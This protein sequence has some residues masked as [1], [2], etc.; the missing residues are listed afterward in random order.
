MN[1]HP[2]RIAALGAVATLLLAGCSSEPGTDTSPSP[3]ATA[4]DTASI[5]GELEIQYFIGGYGEEWWDQVFADF[6][7]AYPDVTI[8]RHG[9]S[10]IHEEMRSRWIAND[11]PDV[12]EIEGAGI[13]ES[14]MVADG[15]LM[16]LTDWIPTI[17]LDDGTML[18]DRFIAPPND[19]DGVLY[20]LPLIYDNRGTWFDETW[21]VENGWEIPMD[22]EAWESS[23]QQIQDEAG[24]PPIATTGV[25]PN[26][27][28]TGVL[29][30]A[31]AGAGGAELLNALV[32]G[33]EGSWSSPEVLAVMQRVQGWVEAGYIDP[34][35]ASLTHTQ[36]QMNFLLHRNAYVPTGFWLPNEM[37]GDVPEDFEFGVI[38]T[39]FNE[40][41][42]KMTVVPEVKTIAVAE[43]AENPEA[44]KA[45]IQFIMTER[46]AYDFAKMAGAMLNITD[47]DLASDPDV[48]AYLKRANDLINDEELVQLLYLSHP[49]HSDLS[50]P[51]GNALVALLL[52][53]STA[54]DFVAAAEAAAASYRS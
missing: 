23:M 21:F 43:N 10:T 36:A 20:S 34:G 16:D 27:F 50:T 35:F 33:E 1:T 26:V 51:I 47:V 28:L 31:W 42:E 11:P 2:G 4:G 54:E 45:F 29:Y 22:I 12:V 53:D 49:M 17:E 14:Q 8:I 41:G 7:A 30:P 5:S 6:E 24:I 44:A 18:I 19:Y 39:P 40:P 3:D 25:Y 15:Q 52:G 32:D 46:Y 48:P 37:A 9:G 13:S 38:P